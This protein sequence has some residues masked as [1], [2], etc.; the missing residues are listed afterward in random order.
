MKAVIALAVLALTG[1]ADRPH[2][3][4]TVDNPWFPLTPGT[5]YHYTGVKDGKPSRDVMTVTRQTKT[6]DGAPCVAVSDKLYLAGRLEEKTT[7]WYSQDQA[8]NVWYFG[9]ATEE[10]APDG[11][12]TSREGSW[13]AG[14]NGARPGIFMFARPKVGQHAQQEFYKGQAED[15][16]QVLAVHKTTLLTKEWT[17]LEPGVIDHKLYKRGVGTILEQTVKGGDERNTLVSVTHS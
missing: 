9:E 6:I 3:S 11:H 5:T 13:R 4:A 7:D 10:L 15:H 17:P 12:V 2:F 16:F 14:V 8:G 1:S